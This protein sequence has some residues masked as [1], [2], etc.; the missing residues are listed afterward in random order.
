MDKIRMTCGTLIRVLDELTGKPP[1]Q[2]GLR[3]RL[4]ITAGEPPAD[5]GDGYYLFARPLE[6]GA[7]LTVQ[8]DGWRQFE[9]RTES[10]PPAEGGIHKIYLEPDG[11]YPMSPEI[12]GI[13]GTARPGD[14]LLIACPEPAWQRRLAEDYEAGAAQLTLQ[15]HKEAGQEPMF[16]DERHTLPVRGAEPEA[17]AEFQIRGTEHRELLRFS[18]RAEGIPGRYRLKTP[19]SHSYRRETA[20]LC[21]VRCAAADETGKFACYWMRRKGGRERF[22]FEILT[23]GGES[24]QTLELR[25]GVRL[26]GV[27][28]AQGAL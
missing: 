6:P 16:R 26:T 22:S 23:R 8:A 19:L 18:E 3:T 2:L 14:I 5:K 1:Q 28:A 12:Y 13:C 10:L 15:V 21:P 7:V 4:R 9:C 17:G 11:H 25:A 27:C 20:A 24:L